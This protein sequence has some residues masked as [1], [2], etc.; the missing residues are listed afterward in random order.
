MVYCPLCSRGAPPILRQAPPTSVPSIS[1]T[2]A[3]LGVLE[4]IHILVTTDRQHPR[5]PWLLYPEHLPAQLRT[6]FGAIF[7]FWHCNSIPIQYDFGFQSSNL[8]LPERQTTYYNCHSYLHYWRHYICLPPLGV[9]Y[10]TPSPLHLQSCLRSVCGW[11]HF[12]IHWE[13]S[14]GEEGR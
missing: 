9:F 14:G 2:S 12:N 6:K 1:Y 7:N 3:T 5:E 13:Y 11:L 8:G 10:L 4:D